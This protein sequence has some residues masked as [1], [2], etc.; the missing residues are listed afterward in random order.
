MKAWIAVVMSS[1]MGVYAQEAAPME[2]QAPA[3]RSMEEMEQIM[4]QQ[5]ERVAALS[6][7]FFELNGQIEGRIQS[8]IEALAAMEDSQETKTRI[9]RMKGKVI[10][11]LKQ[12]IRVLQQQR[13]ANS[14]MMMYMTAE[15][16][17]GSVQGRANDFL[18][19]KMQARIN[20]V[21]T[22]A[23]S[24]HANQE[25]A[26]YEYY[27]KDSY[28][29]NGVKVKKRVSDAYKSNQK[30]STRANMTREELIKDIEAEEFRLTQRANFLKAEQA[31]GGGALPPQQ[32]EELEQLQAFQE[33]LKEKKLEIFDG[34]TVATQPVGDTRHAMELERQLEKAVQELRMANNALR[35]KGIALRQEMERLR[36]QQR[37]VEAKQGK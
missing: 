8:V 10:D 5:E 22:L 24:L 31:R 11:D 2:E 17:E 29:N 3:E 23:G 9:S 36:A 14:E 32:A 21:M 15:Q 26:K 4:A 7:E 25:V 6:E 12:S 27:L 13:A 1:V 16:R 35:Q 30:Q 20:Q 33:I 19:E 18:G 28:D 34:K 37:V